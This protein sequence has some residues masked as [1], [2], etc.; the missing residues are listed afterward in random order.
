MTS[1]AI[2]V[3]ETRRGG[4][5]RTMAGLVASRA[6][7]AGAGFIAQALWT[8]TFDKPTYG[9]YQVIAAALLAV[10][11]FCL[12]GLND[13]ALIS[14]SRNKDGNLAP[15]VRQRLIATA[16]GALVL[17]AWG[18]IHYRDDRAMLLGF[19][20]TAALFAPIQL[21]PIWQSYTNGKRDF[22]MLTLGQI[23]LATASLVGVGVFWIGRLHDP[24]LLP[25]VILASQGLTAAVT[26]WLHWQLRGLKENDEHDDSIVR[27]GHHV[28]VASLLAWVFTSDRLIVGEVLTD[29]D[30]AVL[31]IAILLPAQVKIFFS[32]FEQVFLP[33][34]TAAKSV[35]DAWRYMRSRMVWLWGGYTLLGIAGFLLLPIVIPLFF[36]DKYVE[37]VPYAKWLWLVQCL[38]APFTFL[39]S[40]LNS[41]RDKRFLYIKNIASPLVTISLFAVLIPSYGLAGAIAAR[42]ANGLLL[43]LFHVVYFAYVVRR[44]RASEP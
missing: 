21:A 37:A 27:Y 5:L 30:V 18:W 11:S 17:A 39:A 38:G 36:S 31:A 2:P 25:W 32:A 15:I 26:L 19:V 10:A 24:Q 35:A 1:D 8:R 12:P 7:V 6:Y 4:S 23:L 3:A 14:A 28:T 13:A 34:V 42:I 41:Q 22:R 20:V 40:I 44:V 33:A 16:I 43:V 9:R 29:S